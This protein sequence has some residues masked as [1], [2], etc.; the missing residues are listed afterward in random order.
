MQI[1]KQIRRFIA[2][3]LVVPTLRAVGSLFFDQR[4]LRGRYFDQAITGWR[5]VARS[6]LWQ[7]ILGVNR[8]AR[9]PVSPFIGIDNP[10]GI[11]FDVDDLHNFQTWGCY[12]SNSHGG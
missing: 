6:I 8:A 12:F 1:I 7:R 10:A 2:F 4:Y 3:R 9:Y 11:E 5:W